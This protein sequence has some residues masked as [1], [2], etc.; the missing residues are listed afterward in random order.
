MEANPRVNFRLQELKGKHQAHLHKVLAA[1]EKYYLSYALNL[2]RGGR[3][4]S[5]E[6]QKDERLL[7]VFDRL[8]HYTGAFFY[9]RYDIR[10]SSIEDLKSG[11]F[12]ILE[13]NGSGA[14]PHHI[15]G[16]GNTLFKAYSIVI[17]HWSALFRISRYNYKKGHK[18]WGY[19]RGYAFLK[20]AKRHFT[21]LKHIDSLLDQ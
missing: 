19:L 17:K 5:L 6:H 16:N 9:G 21:Q 3:L 7:A 15:Y 2:S 4:I 8:S 12:S 14:E 20:Q 18:Q 13:Y 11:R 1:G 10:C